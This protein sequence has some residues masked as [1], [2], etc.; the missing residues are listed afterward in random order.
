MKTHTYEVRVSRTAEAGI[1]RGIS[2]FRVEL[3]ERMTVLDA[4]LIFGRRTIR[5]Y[6]AVPAVSACAERVRSR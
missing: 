6:F 1:G 4:L 5:W 2:A 3:E